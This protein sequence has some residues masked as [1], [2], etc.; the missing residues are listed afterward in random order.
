VAAPG[1][2]QNPFLKSCWET[3]GACGRC[4]KKG[5]RGCPQPWTCSG[6]FD[7]HGRIDPDRDDFCDCKNGILRWKTQKGQRII[8]PYNGNPFGGQVMAKSKTQ[9]EKDWDAYLN[10]MQEKLDNPDYSPIQITS[11]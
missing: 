9:D 1:S 11:R 8:T 10:D 7:P 6:R 2:Y 3:C 5:K 4:D